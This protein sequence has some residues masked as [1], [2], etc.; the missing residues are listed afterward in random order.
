M[1][2]NLLTGWSSYSS[3][4]RAADSASKLSISPRPHVHRS[5]V[6]TH[7]LLHPFFFFP[8]SPPRIPHLPPSAFLFGQLPSVL[9]GERPELGIVDTLVQTIL[10]IVVDALSSYQEVLVH[11]SSH[12][13]SS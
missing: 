3:T 1:Q 9:V 5:P 11:V 12:W 7:H 8:D 13:A 6:P 4:N 2:I 10:E